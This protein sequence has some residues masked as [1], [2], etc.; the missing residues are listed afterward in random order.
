MTVCLV[1]VAAVGALAI[2]RL[3]G[4]CLRSPSGRCA[5]ERRCQWVCQW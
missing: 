2:W 3:L 4:L 1:V 5:V